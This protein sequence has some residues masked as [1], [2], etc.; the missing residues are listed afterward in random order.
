MKKLVIGALVVLAALGIGLGLFVSKL[1]ALRA[2]ELDVLEARLTESTK[3]GSTADPLACDAEALRSANPGKAFF[4]VSSAAVLVRT[5]RGDRL[6]PGDYPASAVEGLR[7][8]ETLARL[9]KDL[10]TEVPFA[11]WAQQLERQ[12]IFGFGTRSTDLFVTV[13]PA[14]DALHVDVRS[15]LSGARLCEGTLPKPEGDEPRTIHDA[16]TVA[17]KLA[18]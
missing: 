5:P 8:S 6:L 2:A 12:S 11:Q 16:V 10:V 3:P 14:D 17:L 4:G 1:R 18:P 15:Y 7:Q 9:T 13:R